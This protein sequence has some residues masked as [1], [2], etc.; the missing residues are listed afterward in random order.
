MPQMS[1]AKRLFHLITKPNQDY[2]A[3]TKQY[4]AITSGRGEAPHA[5]DVA[6][7]ALRLPISWFRV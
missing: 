6:R 2:Y 7:E 3:I 4:Y 5:A 1:H